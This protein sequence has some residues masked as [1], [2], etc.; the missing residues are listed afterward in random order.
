MR[1]FLVVSLLA[2]SFVGSPRMTA[3]QDSCDKQFVVSQ[4]NLP[5]TTQLSPSEQATV[6]ARV[7]GRCF[8]DEKSGELAERVRDALQTF[9]YFRATVSAPTMTIVDVSRHPQPISLNV[10][11]V[12]GAR[13]KVREVIW[14]G[15]GA[16]SSDQLE[17]ISQILPGDIL[18]MSKVRETLEVVLRLYAANGYPKAS[19]VPQVQVQV[20]EGGHWVSLQFHVVEGAQSP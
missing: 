20:H 15:Y 5:T 13:Y 9:G 16:L 10:E 19:V 3:A 7:I 14:S 6:R 1:S 2:V 11:L 12:E 18:D 4:V 17:S 8:D